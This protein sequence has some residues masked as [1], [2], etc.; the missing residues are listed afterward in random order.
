MILSKSKNTHLLCLFYH[1]FIT[2]FS[3][4][5]VNTNF[6]VSNLELQIKSNVDIFHSWL[7]CIYVA[8]PLWESVKMRFTHEMGTW[9]SFETLKILEFDYKGQNTSH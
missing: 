2:C 3:V 6:K 9:E 7:V 4:D 5:E 8:N 1:V